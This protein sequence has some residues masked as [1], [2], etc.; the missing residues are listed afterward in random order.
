MPPHPMNVNNQLSAMPGLFPQHWETFYFPLLEAT[1]SH[2]RLLPLNLATHPMKTLQGRKV[3]LR[4][5]L[6]PEL[7]P[8]ITYRCLLVL[9]LCLLIR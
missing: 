5:Q 1:G 7:V 3:L 9:L 6:L 2:S 8:L 4:H